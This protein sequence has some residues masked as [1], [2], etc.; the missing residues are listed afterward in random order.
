MLRTIFE[1]HTVPEAYSKHA[2]GAVYTQKK[3]APG[4][5]LTWNVLPDYYWSR[6]YMVLE[7]MVQQH[8]V[9]DH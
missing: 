2:P 8:M 3:N 1:M 4:A 6:A 9:M 5:Y 7:H